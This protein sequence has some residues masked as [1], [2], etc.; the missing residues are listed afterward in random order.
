MG[1]Q[2]V[3]VKMLNI[4]VK[5]I[6]PAAAKIS[7]PTGLPLRQERN[8]DKWMRLKLLYRFDM[9]QGLLLC[10]LELF[11]GRFC[12]SDAGF[13]SRRSGLGGCGSATSPLIDPW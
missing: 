3:L 4:V 5:G 6:E 10:V 7:F 8:L 11:K 12:F 9:T 2:V 1:I 13:F